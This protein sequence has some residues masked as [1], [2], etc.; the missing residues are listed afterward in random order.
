[1]TG[2]N[3]FNHTIGD[4][5]L[6]IQSYGAVDLANITAD[7]NAGYGVFVNT[8]G[9]ITMT[10]SS[11]NRNGEY[12]WSLNTTNGLAT[13]KGVFGFGNT[14]GNYTSSA[15]VTVRGCPVPPPLPVVVVIPDNEDPDKTPHGSTRPPLVYNYERK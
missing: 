13:L 4:S 12:G 1:M 2:L 8:E 6:F 3:I 7:A 14:N 9:P 11:L 10:C 5:G 15:L